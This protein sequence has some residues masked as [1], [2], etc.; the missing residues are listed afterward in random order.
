MFGKNFHGIVQ[1]VIEK[2]NAFGVLKAGFN[3]FF[4]EKND[5]ENRQVTKPLA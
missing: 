3:I 1:V 4:N 5:G 2:M